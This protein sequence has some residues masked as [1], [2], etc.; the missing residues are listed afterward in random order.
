[1]RCGCDGFQRIPNATV[2]LTNGQRHERDST[3]RD[4]AR[5]PAAARSMERRLSRLDA[6]IAE[7]AG[8]AVHQ[9][10]D[11]AFSMP[12][13]IDHQAGLR[14]AIDRDADFLLRHDD[15][16]VKPPGAIRNG[17]DSGFVKREACPCA[18][19]PPC[20]QATRRT[21]QRDCASA[22]S[23]AN[24]NGRKYTASKL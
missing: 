20:T 4:V 8:Y 21:A 17:L 5:R 16:G 22:S 24:R 18:A 14:A 23:S 12:Q 1:R 15:A 7:G 11:A 13:A 2:G 10:G 6:E 9:Q 19:P 3:G